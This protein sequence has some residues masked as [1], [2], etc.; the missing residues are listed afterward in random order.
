MSIP[1]FMLATNGAFIKA[2]N[3]HNSQPGF[4]IEDS[5]HYHVHMQKLI[6]TYLWKTQKLETPKEKC[7]SQFTLTGIFFSI[8]LLNFILKNPHIG[9]NPN[10]FV[11]TSFDQEY[12]QWIFG[13]IMRTNVAPTLANIIIIWRKK[14]NCAKVQGSS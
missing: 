7:Q 14:T 12:F 9:P 5:L 6:L 11:F 3:W 10:P 1:I 13:I 8:V 2:C 4:I